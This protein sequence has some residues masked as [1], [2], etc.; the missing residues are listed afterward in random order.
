MTG[1]DFSWMYQPESFNPILRTLGG[2][3]NRDLCSLWGFIWG[4]P[5]DVGVI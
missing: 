3:P 1:N 2:T 4:L 5:R